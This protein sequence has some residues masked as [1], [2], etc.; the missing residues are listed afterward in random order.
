MTPEVFFEAGMNTGEGPVWDHRTA[1]LYCVDSTNP[2]IW[3]FAQDGRVLDRMALPERIGFIALTESP[4][5]FIAGLQTGLFDISLSDRSLDFLMDPEPDLPGNR[6][7]DG[8]VDLDGALVF[9]SLDDGLT[10]PTGRTYRLTGDGTLQNYDSGYIVSNGPYPHP[11]GERFFHVDSEVGIVR[12]FRRNSDR[13]FRR[14]GTFCD[15]D[16]AEWGIPDGIVCDTDGGVWI[17]HWDGGC[18]SRFD[19]DGR[20]SH[21]IDLPVS[22]VT[23]PAFGGPGMKTM[24]LTTAN[25]DIDCVREP[26]AGSVFV[27][28]TEFTGL[29]SGIWKRKWTDSRAR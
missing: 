6:I 9:G 20:R 28:E 8:I 19:S 29:E 27:I 4:G 23:K 21:S 15:W 18:V 7:N 11:D 22:R 13:S 1:T 24:F 26:L 16:M 14:D 10:E 17:A 3:A 25:R 12:Q 2:A 5:C